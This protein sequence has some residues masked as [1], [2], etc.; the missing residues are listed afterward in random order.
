MGYVYFSI[1]IPFSH[2]ASYQMYFARMMYSSIHIIL[3]EVKV[4]SLPTPNIDCLSQSDVEGNKEGAIVT[5]LLQNMKPVKM[6]VT[7]SEI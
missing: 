6:L 5:T 7:T 2:I 3:H 4:A 1:F